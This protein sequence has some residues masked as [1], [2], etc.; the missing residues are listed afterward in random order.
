MAGN[1]YVDVGSGFSPPRTATSLSNN[2][3]FALP[4]T[5]PM[6][7]YKIKTRYIWN[8]G[9]VSLPIANQ[10]A[11]SSPL[12]AAIA[13]LTSP[14][15][16]KIV[17]WV[18]RRTGDYPML[19]DPTPDNANQVLASFDLEFDD[20]EFTA[21]QKPIITARGFYIYLLLKPIG[22]KNGIFHMGGS[23][24][25]TLKAAQSTVTSANFSSSILATGGNEGAG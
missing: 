14:Y 8:N 18:A 25:Y 16:F 7:G 20:P 21:D 15:G 19:P 5:S 22:V 2:G 1:T 6:D 12:N 23:P 11:N 24:A 13:Q 9:T 10:G 4:P 3:V 17:Q